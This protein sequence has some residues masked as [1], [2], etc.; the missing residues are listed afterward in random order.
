MLSEFRG[1]GLARQLLQA[2]ENWAKQ[3]GYQHI[4]VN[5]LNRPASSLTH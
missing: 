5:T 3:Q 4:G 1:L 2:Q